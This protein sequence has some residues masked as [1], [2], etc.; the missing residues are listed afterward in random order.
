M[1]F[2][3]LM[4]SVKRWTRPLRRFCF[5]DRPF[6]GS[7]EYWRDR[8]ARGGNSG[9]GSYKQ[10]AEFKAEFLNTLVHEQHIQSVMEFG[11]GD[12]N[13]L[14]LANYPQYLGLDVSE[15][16]ITMCQ[17]QFLGDATKQFALLV[18]T[19]EKK[20]GLTLSLDVVYH[21]VEDDVFQLYMERLFDCA[22]QLVVVYS[23]NFEET[24]AGGGQHVRHRNFTGWVEEHRSHWKL[25]LHAPN[26]YSHKEHGKQGSLA[27]FYVFGHA[28]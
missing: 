14:A 2:R 5:G 20:A 8:Y 1:L 25:I 21:L 7:A 17:Q 26:R 9:V 22:E 11:C 12:G 27:D 24:V 16:A 13:Q 4:E 18:E 15:Q 6:A 28:A 10:L 19:P 23:S 3:P